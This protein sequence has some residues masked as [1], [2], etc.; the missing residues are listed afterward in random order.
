MSCTILHKCQKDEV[1]L[2]WSIT[3]HVLF[4]LHNITVYYYR[5]KHYN[6]KQISNHICH[7]EYN[8]M[9][10]NY[11]HHEIKVPLKYISK[12]IANYRYSLSAYKLRLH[13]IDRNLIVYSTTKPAYM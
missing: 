6:I 13:C 2:H 11:F 1:H 10:I 8:I 5:Q 12:I 3:F 7:R 4:H 9:L